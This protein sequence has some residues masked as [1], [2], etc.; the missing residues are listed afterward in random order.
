[1]TTHDFSICHPKAVMGDGKY[2]ISLVKYFQWSVQLRM[3]THDFS[4]WHPTAVMGDG[5]YC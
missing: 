2:E 3:T 5:K 1:M 4:I